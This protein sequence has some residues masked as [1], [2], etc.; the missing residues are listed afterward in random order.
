MKLFPALLLFCVVF[1]AG[2]T[3]LVPVE[4]EVETEVLART[5]FTDRIENFFEY[6]PLKSGEPSEFLIHLTDLLDGSPVSDARVQLLVRSEGS[7]NQ[8][9]ETT[10]LVGRVTG[11]YVAELAVPSPGV[12]D[13]E[14]R[15]QND[16]IDES[17]TL[18]G[19]E[20]E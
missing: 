19:F 15:V 9:A 6:S 10:A 20:V 5:D 14:F 7:R 13:I 2:C 3:T 4:E 18:T 12:Y 11:I 16:G 1:L 8:V 17:M